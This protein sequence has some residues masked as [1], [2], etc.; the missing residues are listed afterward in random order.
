MMD[1]RLGP[2][3]ERCPD[4]SVPDARTFAAL[5]RRMLAA[6]KTSV[7]EISDDAARLVAVLEWTYCP[8][9]HCSHPTL[10]QMMR[11]GDLTPSQL[12][13]ARRELVAAGVLT[14]AP[15]PGSPSLYRVKREIAPT[16]TWPAVERAY[17]GMVARAAARRATAEEPR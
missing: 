15:V 17:D 4:H 3:A 12:Y 2:L 8:E 11:D 9:C 10:A 7:P 5:M 16:S 14:V 13:G 6:S 1:R